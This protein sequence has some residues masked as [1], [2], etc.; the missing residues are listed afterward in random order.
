VKGQEDFTGFVKGEPFFVYGKKCIMR[1]RFEKNS[2]G[3][4][5]WC[6]STAT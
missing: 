5:H 3:K 2:G 6:F 1:I 4:N